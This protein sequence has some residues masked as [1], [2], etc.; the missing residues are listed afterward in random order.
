MNKLQAYLCS[1][2]TVE[3]AF[4]HFFCHGCEECPARS[5]CH[6]QPEGTCCRENF[7]AWAKQEANHDQ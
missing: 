5:Y 4:Q 7:R 3:T 2:V 1:A 6:A